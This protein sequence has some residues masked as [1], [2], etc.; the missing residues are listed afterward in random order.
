MG[1]TIIITEHPEQIC[2]AYPTIF[3]FN[4]INGER[5]Y[6]RLRHGWWRLENETTGRIL[7]SGEAGKL[8]LDSI[9]NWEEAKMLCASDG[10]F[11]KN[12]IE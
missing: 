1:T 4:D 3:E 12:E 11:I 9:C 6:F 10:I 8:D 5:Y 7:A 2:Y